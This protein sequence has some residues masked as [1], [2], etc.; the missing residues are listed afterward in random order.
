M[1]RAAEDSK[2]YKELWPAWGSIQFLIRCNCDVINPRYNDSLSWMWS[3]I[4]GHEQK[5]AN[6][7]WSSL[8]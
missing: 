5:L 6:E 4:P 3:A 7:I 2:S 8:N 1:A